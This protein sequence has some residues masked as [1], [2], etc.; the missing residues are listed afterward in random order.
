MKTF[1]KRVTEST[2]VIGGIDKLGVV[3]DL[4]Q[5]TE[6]V[7]SGQTFFRVFFLGGRPCGDP[8]KTFFSKKSAILVCRSEIRSINMLMENIDMRKLRLDS[9]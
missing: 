1:T 7:N 9:L 8:L 3:G 6:E 4:L 5:V 2:V